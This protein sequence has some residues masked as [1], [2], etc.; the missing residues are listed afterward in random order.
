MD[1]DQF[2]VGLLDELAEGVAAHVAG[3][4][5]DHP[6][7]HRFPLTGADLSASLHEIIERFMFFVLEPEQEV[8][9][10]ECSRARWPWS[11]EPVGG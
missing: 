1:P 2:E 3:R 8:R 5:L 9:Q 6:Q 4:E 10:W 11:P 7:S